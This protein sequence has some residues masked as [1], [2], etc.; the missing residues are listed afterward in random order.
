MLFQFNISYFLLISVNRNNLPSSFFVVLF[1][2]NIYQ[3]LVKGVCHRFNYIAWIVEQAVQTAINH[4]T[5]YAAKI[6]EW[7]RHLFINFLQQQ[8][9]NRQ[10]ERKSEPNTKN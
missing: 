5:V 4:C 10:T 7:N 6:L 1:N 9:E 8:I 2:V 3:P